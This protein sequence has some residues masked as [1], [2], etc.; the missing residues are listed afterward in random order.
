MELV[1]GKGPMLKTVCAL[2]GSP[3][4]CGLLAAV[5]TGGAPLWAADALSGAANAPAAN[6]HRIIVFINRI[7]QAHTCKNAI[8][9]G[10]TTGVPAKE[11][12]NLPHREAFDKRFFF[13][14]QSGLQK[15]NLSA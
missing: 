2:G 5:S 9:P 3:S 15:K 6:N 8:A 4:S 1:T 12:R 10:F 14:V 7:E 11:K 13:G